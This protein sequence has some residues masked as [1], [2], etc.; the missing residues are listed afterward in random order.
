[1]AENYSEIEEFA[2]ATPSYDEVRDIV[3]APARARGIAECEVVCELLDGLYTTPAPV[4][5]NPGLIA[6]PAVVLTK[7][8]VKWLKFVFTELIPEYTKD[9][10]SGGYK[11]RI[12]ARVVKEFDETGEADDLVEIHTYTKSHTVVVAGETTRDETNTTVASKLVKGKRT[13]FA[14]ALAKE[15]YLKFGNRK[16]DEA[17]CLVTRKWLN[18]FLEGDKFKD[19]RTCDKINAID[20]AL[21]LSFVPTEEFKQMKLVMQSKTM[22]ARINEVKTVYGRVFRL[23][24]GTL[25]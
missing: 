15:A 24:P 18:K 17:N 23:Q 14:L 12:A 6:E 21:F 16:F 25:A 8:G 13:K 3:E 4:M 2:V 5:S 1:M 10:F 9:L 7:W 11:E 19:L 22:D 20:R